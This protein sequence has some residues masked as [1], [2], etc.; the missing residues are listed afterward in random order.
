LVISPLQNILYLCVVAS[1]CCCSCCCCN[2]MHVLH[3]CAG[4][5]N[6]CCD[7]SLADGSA[8]QCYC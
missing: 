4:T 8:P 7:T 3:Y 5:A 6:G 1:G 2:Y